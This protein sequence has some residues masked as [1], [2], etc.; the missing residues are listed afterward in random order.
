[1]TIS[2]ATRKA[3]PYNGNNVTTSFPFTFKVFSDSDVLV[4]KTDAA[5][6][7]A[8]LALATDYTVILNADQ[9][10]SPGGSVDLPAALAS[11]YKLTIS[12]ALSA[13]QPVSLTNTGGFY[14]EVL[15]TALDRLTILLQ[16]VSEQASRAVKTPISSSTSPDTIVAELL[17][18]AA[19]AAASAAAAANSAT[20][21]ANAV[22]AGSLGFTP[23]NKAGDTMTGN[24]ALPGINVG[25]SGVV[26]ALG[27]AATK[28]TGAAAGNVPLV[29]TKSATK[30]LPGLNYDI[31]QIQPVAASVGSNALT[32][33]LNP[34]TLDF[35][36][37]TLTDGAAN[38]RQVGAAISLTISTGSTLGTVNATA[39][40]I[41]ILAIDNA[42]TVELAAV[43]LAG[44]N[45]LDETTLINTT[46]EGGVGGANSANVIYS[47][48]ARTGVPFRVVGF[49]DITEATAGT[50]AT[51]PTLVQGVGGQALA[52]MASLGMGQTWQ[53]MSASR[54]TGTTYYNT[55][56][57]P[58]FV[59]VRTGSNQSAS[60]YVSGQ[61]IG[62]SY[63]TT[64]Y[65]GQVVALVPPGASYY[66]NTGSVW[67]AWYELR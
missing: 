31:P 49:V 51:A 47:A 38:T 43:N 18:A 67:A 50:W 15:N 2:S 59:S 3:G 27:N 52:A 10:A 19:S 29:G 24:L 39:A 32:L 17:A 45:N 33:T 35:R 60:I 9:N 44:G 8:T 20:A 57:R 48:T 22:P 30:I 14:P 34:T 62:F 55:T 26:T 54:A 28:T 12:S 5:G 23:V 13:L 6:A 25:G 64:G 7:E 11:T 36:S 4:V 53:D 42:G 16:Q 46:A 1:M 21:A 41:A 40:R 56:G 37:A 63:A 61:N 66:L 58:I 65:A